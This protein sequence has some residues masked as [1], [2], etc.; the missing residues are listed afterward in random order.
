MMLRMLGLQTLEARQVLSA[1]PILSD[2][3]LTIQGNDRPNEIAVSSNVERN[4]LTVKVDERVHVF[5]NHAV[6]AIAVHGNGGNDSIVMRSNVMQVTL[7]DGGAGD[8]LIV[9]GSGV[10]VIF[11]GEGN[12][13]LSGVNGN[14]YVIGGD[15]H[16]NL[17]GGDGDDWLFGDATNSYPEGYDD[18]VQYAL[19]FATTGS[20]RDVI[21]GNS[22]NDIIL[23]GNSADR[24]SGNDGNDIVV[25]GAGDDVLEGNDGNDLLLGDW[26]NAGDSDDQEEEPSLESV[27]P[28]AH[29]LARAVV[30][31]TDERA[32][33]NDL[34]YGGI[35]DDVIWGMRGDDRVRTGDGNDI[36]YGGAGDDRISGDDGNDALYG[37][38][39]NDYLLGGDGNDR[40]RGG[41]GNDELHGGLGNDALSGGDGRD[42]LF[43]GDGDD[44]LI[45][46]AGSDYFNGGLGEDEIRARD[47]ES[48]VILIDDL[49]KL[50]I[51]PEDIVQI[52]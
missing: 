31:E 42:A 39:G 16:D 23:A 19:D 27:N 1:V 4:T 35:G 26:R 37:G 34:I 21:E 41:D 15:G 50:F 18:P 51:D 3:L 17:G 36:V 6:Q 20:G 43:G 38:L 5:R 45:G 7:L 11:G 32:S 14:D 24:A 29:R 2:G 47:G 13:R 22:G 52:P 9:G 12:D 46:G 28:T 44:L 25:G 49:D 33:Y 40:I 8:D 30:I 48:D 10:D